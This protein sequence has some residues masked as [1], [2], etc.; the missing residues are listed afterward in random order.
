MVP[1]SSGMNENTSIV[2]RDA[3]SFTQEWPQWSNQFTVFPITKP[4][5]RSLVRVLSEYSYRDR[6]VNRIMD[7]SLDTCN[8]LQRGEVENTDCKRKDQKNS[9]RP[10]GQRRS[11]GWDHDAILIMKA[12][13][14]DYQIGFCEVVDNHNIK[15]YSMDGGIDLIG[16]HRGVKFVMQ[17]KNFTEDKV[18][19]SLVRDSIEGLSNYPP[20]TSKFSHSRIDDAIFGTGCL[21]NAWRIFASQYGHVSSG[22]SG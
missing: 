14:V 15:N 20:D 11:V 10:Q 4:A 21:E 1:S 22:V 12:N 9:A 2:N 17:C 8:F 16:E 19:A 7:V 18:N 3:Y 6:I 5:S 13:N